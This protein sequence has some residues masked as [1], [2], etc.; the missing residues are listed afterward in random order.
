MDELRERYWRAFYDVKK[1]A[2]YYKYY[3]ISSSRWGKLISVICAALSMGFVAS[4][5][6]SKAFPKSWAFLTF[7]CQLVLAYQPFSSF[8]ERK[9]AAAYIFQDMS[10]LAKEAENTWAIIQVTADK[11]EIIE[12]IDDLLTRQDAIEERFATVSTFPDNGFIHKKAIKS[13]DEYFRRF[14]T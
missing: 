2:F 7:A 1:A 13:T 12:R 10:K 8:S 4:G 11:E 6:F 14:Q 5:Y 3:G 9:A